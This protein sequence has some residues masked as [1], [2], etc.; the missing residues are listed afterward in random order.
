[1]CAA[2]AA[3]SCA[4]PSP[5]SATHFRIGGCPALRQRV[6]RPFLSE[7]QR[8]ALPR[9][10]RDLPAAT[11]RL[12]AERDHQLEVA[13]RRVGAVSVGLVDR[14]DVSALED[15]RLDRLHLVA[16]A[17]RHDDERRVCR[18][19]D[20]ELVL[21]DPDRLDED[22][23]DPHASSTRTTS[24]ARPG[25]ATHVPRV[26]SDRMNTPAS[27]CA[28]HP[29]AVPQDGASRVGARGIDRDHAD[30]LPSLPVGLDQPVA[31]RRLA[32][33]RVAGDP[34]DV[35]LARVREEVLPGYRRVCE[36]RS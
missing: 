14:E 4:T 24:R 28:S 18:A 34:D 26:A 36:T 21:P 35:G 30:A 27:G 23:V 11:E 16:H 20:L 22:H 15:A 8:L 25:E 5:F 17:G 31:E 7:E 33:A 12:V 2:S 1:M 6:A 29:D 3:T 9:V 32:R 19:R 10:P 13:H